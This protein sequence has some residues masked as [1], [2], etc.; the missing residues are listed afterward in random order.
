MPA[1]GVETI[2][3]RSQPVAN[4]DK[5]FMDAGIGTDSGNDCTRTLAR[6]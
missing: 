5:D 2:F 1:V 6:P 4:E 3:G